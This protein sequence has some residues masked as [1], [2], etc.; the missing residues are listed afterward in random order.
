MVEEVSTTLDVH[1]VEKKYSEK[2][3]E[4]TEGILDRPGVGGGSGGTKLRTNF[5]CDF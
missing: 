3:K 4:K 5:K 2:E 1:F